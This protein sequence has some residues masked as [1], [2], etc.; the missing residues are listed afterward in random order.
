MRTRAAWVLLCLILCTRFR[1]SLAL[2]EDHS[3]TVAITSA[4]IRIRGVNCAQPGALDNTGHSHQIMEAPHCFGVHRE[5]VAATW[6]NR[7]LAAAACSAYFR[8]LA[9]Q[10]LARAHLLGW[11][12]W[13]EELADKL[14]AT[15]LWGG[16]CA[17]LPPGAAIP[18][19]AL[20]AGGTFFTGTRFGT[21]IPHEQ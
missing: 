1:E 13:H 11:A 16:G 4:I 5:T 19:P 18:R 7:W 17:P 3:V 12:I 10:L 20:G 8:F 15:K 6:F 9:V 21:K 2:D 14:S